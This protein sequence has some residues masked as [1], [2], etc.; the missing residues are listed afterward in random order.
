MIVSAAN[1]EYTLQDVFGFRQQGLDSTGVA[2]GE[3]FATGY[4]PQCVSRFADAGVEVSPSL[5]TKTG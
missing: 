2:K 1:G 5:F 3:F 4:V